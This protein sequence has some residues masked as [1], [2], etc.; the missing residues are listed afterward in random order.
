MSIRFQRLGP[1]GQNRR[2]NVGHLELIRIKPCR[3]RSVS[4]SRLD[5]PQLPRPAH[6]PHLLGV[7]LRVLLVARPDSQCLAARGK[8]LD[9]LL[10]PTALLELLGHVRALLGNDCRELH[11]LKQVVTRQGCAGKVQRAD[12]GQ[13]GLGD[14]GLTEVVK[15]SINYVCAKVGG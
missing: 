4:F 2:T 1:Y 3:G 15:V 9:E 5:G 10:H 13:Y 11:A 12:V 8:R 6:L 14:I 7:G